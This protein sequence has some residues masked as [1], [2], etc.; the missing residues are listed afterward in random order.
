MIARLSAASLL[1]LGAAP[2][3]GLPRDALRQAMA[4]YEQAQIGADRIALNRL[5]AD[6]YLLV[7]GGGDRED[8]KTF[9]ADLVDPNF[10]INPYRIERPILR[11][12]SNGAVSAGIAHET[13]TSGG[14]AFD[15]CIRFAD[16][17]KLIDG[18]WRVAFTQVA[19]MPQPTA[20]KCG[21]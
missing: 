10:K 6:D 5:L 21:A 19:R 20:G 3:L 8:K 4:N 11:R 2:A 18:H 15:A 7:N 16:T 12:W 13:G 17:W 1:L 9:I 14:K